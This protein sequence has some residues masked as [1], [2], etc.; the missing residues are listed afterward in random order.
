MHVGECWYQADTAPSFVDIFAAQCLIWQ[1]WPIG[2]ALHPRTKI[3]ASL[4]SG[5]ALPCGAPLCCFG[6]MRFGRL[7]QLNNTSCNAFLFFLGKVFE[8]SKGINC[9]FES[10]RHISVLIVH[11]CMIMSI[12]TQ[13]KSVGCQQWERGLSK[14]ASAGHDIARRHGYCWR[15]QIESTAMC[16][17]GYQPYPQAP[18]LPCLSNLNCQRSQNKQPR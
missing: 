12:L 5:K 18:P 11:V 1:T 15:S 14:K 2:K 4:F 7:D 6:P 17:L 16:K 3:F 13:S 10:L 9:V 8:G